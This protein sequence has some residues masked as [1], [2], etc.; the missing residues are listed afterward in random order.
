[1]I[2]LY[3]HIGFQ[4]TATTFLQQ[5]IFPYLTTVSNITITPPEK[6]EDIVLKLLCNEL[7]I[8]DREYLEALFAEQMIL[9][10]AVFSNEALSSGTISTGFLTLSERTTILHTIRDLFKHLDIKILLGIREQSDIVRS[11]YLQYLHQGGT[12]DING[13]FDLMR[14]N[15]ETVFTSSFLKALEYSPYIQQLHDA[16][17]RENLFVFLYEDLKQDLNAFLWRLMQFLGEPEIPDLRSRRPNRSY[18]RVEAHVARVINRFFRLDQNRGGL[19]PV[20]RVPCIGRLEPRRFLQSRFF[21]RSRPWTLPDAIVRDI[22]SHYRD[23]NRILADQL[24]LKLSP[25]YFD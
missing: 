14:E 19:L 20:L 16:F 7:T 6:Y 1:M 2:T 24:D 5:Q 21:P 13:F 22:K 9:S 23:D 4:K 15:G 17:G 12:R 10:K 8:A 18:G 25:H 11:F 3:I